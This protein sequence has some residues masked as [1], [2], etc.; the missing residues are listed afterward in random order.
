MAPPARY[1]VPGERLCST[2]EASAGSGTYAR[3]G[4]IF[5]S[6]AG[7]LQKCAEGGGVSAERGSGGCGAGVGGPELSPC[8][9]LAA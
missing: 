3:H 9:C 4:S 7:C 2:E 1:C 5:A 6:L 8:V